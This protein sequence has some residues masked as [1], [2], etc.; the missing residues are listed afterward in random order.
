MDG[1]QIV[2]RVMADG[3]VHAET[4][5]IAGP[6]CLDSIELLEDLL[7][8]TTLMSSFTPEYTATTSTPTIEVDHE[9]HQQ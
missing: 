6:R 3:A 2:V 7:D 1:E 5:G 4:K 9:Q 8:A